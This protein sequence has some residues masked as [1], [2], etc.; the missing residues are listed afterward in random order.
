MQ[1]QAAVTLPVGAEG[2]AQ[3]LAGFRE[4]ARVVGAGVLAGGARSIEPWMRARFCIN[5][6]RLT[7]A[8]CPAPMPITLIRPLARSA[9]RLPAM[10]GPPISSRTTSNGPWSK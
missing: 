10:F 9:S 3:R 7:S 6:N 2:P 4:E 1:R 5:A 8:E